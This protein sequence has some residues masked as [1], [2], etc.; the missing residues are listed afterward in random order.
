MYRRIMVCFMYIIVNTLHK[1]C[2][3][4]IILITI[5]IIII[6]II[7]NSVCLFKCPN[8]GRCVRGTYL[9]NILVP[10]TYLWAG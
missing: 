9:H 5:I 7:I 6:I 3:N 1:G 2:T 10:Y 4:I 8:F